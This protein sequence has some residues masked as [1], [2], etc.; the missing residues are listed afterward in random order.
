MFRFSPLDIAV[1]DRAGIGL[2]LQE[3]GNLIGDHHRAVLATGAADGDRQVVPAFLDVAREQE[4][5]Q[6][7]DAAEEAL[8]GLLPEDVAAD[9]AA[10]AADLAQPPAPW[11][12][13]EEPDI[14]RE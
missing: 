13:S 10:P 9:P 6:V 14:R 3:A 5:E 2:L 7:P 12:G 4:L 11:R 1:D 8:R